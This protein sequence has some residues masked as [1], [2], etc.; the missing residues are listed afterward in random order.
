MKILLGKPHPFFHRHDLILF[1]DVT[2][3]V[4]MCNG[5]VMVVVWWQVVDLVGEEKV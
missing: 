4:Q 3:V 2:V 5:E 1:G